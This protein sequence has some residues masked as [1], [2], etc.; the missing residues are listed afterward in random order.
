M[1]QDEKK[2]EYIELIYDLIFVFIIGRNN[3]LLRV[4]KDGFIDPGAFLTYV[5]TALIVLQI[6]YATTLFVNRYGENDHLMHAAIFVNM[7]LLY[8]MAR[9]I[10]PDWREEYYVFNGAW[11]LILLNIA[12]L[13]LVQWK[14]TSVAK[15]WE[16][17]PIKMNLLSILLQG[18]IIVVSFPVFA[19][20]GFPL[21]PAAMV[22]GMVMTVAG[23]RA[24][25][26]MPVDFG[27]LT[28][29][30]M[31]YVVFT[32]GKMIIGISGYFEGGFNIRT[33]YFSLV[34]FLIVAG[35]FFSYGLLYDHFVDREAGTDSTW[36]VLVHVF[37]I[38]SL[39]HITAAMEFMREDFQ[40]GTAHAAQMPEAERKGADA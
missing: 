21:S 26:L 33:I 36:Y 25:A 31:L 29:R 8:F 1:Q 32:F 22:F 14:R 3:N 34:G 4:M 27:H 5:L 40:R 19:L 28:E 17:E 2:V 30:V 20:T 38:L 24:N 7:Y 9:G 6:W 13:Y 23:N 12:L 18:G 37:L 10:Q 11:L 16:L 39:N 15:P 35:L